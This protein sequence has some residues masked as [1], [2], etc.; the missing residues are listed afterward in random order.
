LLL[1]SVSADGHILIRPNGGY[2]GTGAP[3]VIENFDGIGTAPANQVALFDTSGNQIG[4]FYGTILQCQAGWANCPAGTFY[5]YATDFSCG[6]LLDSALNTPFC[7]FNVYKS[8]DRVQWTPIGHVFNPSNSATN[9]A[10]I[11]QSAEAFKWCDEPRMAYNTN[12]GQFNLWF[13][14]YGQTSVP[15]GL[16]SCAHPGGIGEGGSTDCANPGT[17]PTLEGGANY[18]FDDVVPFDWSGNHYILYNDSTFTCH[19][20]QL[21]SNGLTGTG[22]FGPG[23]GYECE[24]NGEFQSGNNVFFTKGTAPCLYCNGVGVTY[25]YFASPS[26]LTAAAPTA[27]STLLALSCGGQPF[28]D[29]T[30]T[31][32]G[33]TYILFH[34]ALFA[35]SG[36]AQGDTADGYP[37]QALSNNYFGIIT[38]SGTSLSISNCV[39]ATTLIG[40]TA[41][42]PPSPPSGATVQDYLINGATP[43]YNSAAGSNGIS[44]GLSKLQVITAP[45]GTT[46]GVHLVIGINCGTVSSDCNGFVA[47]SSANVTVSLAPWTGTAPGATVA[48]AV[49][50]GS[51]LSWS[52]QDTLFTWSSPATLTAGQYAII[53]QAGN[54]NGYGTVTFTYDNNNAYGSA[55]GSTYTSTGGSWTQDSNGASGT[56]SMKFALMP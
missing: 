11:C 51:T 1:L 48:S 28:L 54:N 16:V 24:G 42:A 18:P 43:T 55:N 25:Y 8:T 47:N 13:L 35:T 14:V 15:L 32:G 31:L 20:E 38:V 6:Y 40:G 5:G 4:G 9:W 29:D 26:S 17:A 56:R 7:G 52:P 44:S 30:A 36:V 41:A 53:I 12:T 33:N 2:G 19:I 37:N 10:S 49:V 50:A 27:G 46:H 21:T 45:S 22:T 3:P 39:P 23:F 34:S